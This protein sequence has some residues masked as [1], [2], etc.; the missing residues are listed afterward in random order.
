MLYAPGLTNLDSSDCIT[1]TPIYRIVYVSTLHLLTFNA[2]PFSILCIQLLGGF[3]HMGC[4]CGF[5]VLYSEIL[6]Y[7]NDSDTYSVC[8]NE[9]V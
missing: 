2:T 4:L 7:D 1:S 6:G 5:L 8:S 3:H 9:T